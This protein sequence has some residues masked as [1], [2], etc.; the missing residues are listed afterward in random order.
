M[1]NYKLIEWGIQLFLFMPLYLTAQEDIT[2]VWKGTL[3][4]DSTQQYLPYE[5]AISNNK[6]ELS[7]YSYT[8]FKNDSVEDMGIK[9]IWIK[10]KKD[11]I[12]IEDIYLLTNTYTVPFPK[13]VSKRIDLMLTINDSAMEMNGS[14]KIYPI[15]HYLPESGT[16]VIRKTNDSWKDEPLI[17]KLSEMNLLH[18][19][20]FTGLNKK[21]ELSVTNKRKNENPVSKTDNQ[22][23]QNEI[24]ISS[25]EKEKKA[26]ADVDKRKTKIIQDM[27]FETDSLVFTLYDNGIV[28]GDTV[29]VLLNGNIILP[30]QGL[31]EKPVSKVIYTKDIPDSSVFVLYAE[32][33]GNIPPNT[34]LL[35]IYDGKTRHEIF[36]STDLQTNEAIILKKKNN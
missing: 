24:S 29:S 23:W 19:L 17:K 32:N 25:P 26:A 28:D 15:I 20:S 31:T 6:G 10:R 35:L 16:I 27:Y 5:V 8:L 21:Q 1:K 33:L 18:T 4:D 30:N 22:G 13:Y 7:G 11:N 2:G 34:G 36:F 3:Y 12:L 9:K 14:W